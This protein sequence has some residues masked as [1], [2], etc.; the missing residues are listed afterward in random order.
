MSPPHHASLPGAPSPW[1]PVGLRGRIAISFG[2][3]SVVIVGVLAAAT[4]SLTSQYLYARRE[5]GAADQARS[6][7]TLVRDRLQRSSPDLPALLQGLTGRP[8][9]G[10]AVRRGATWTTLGDVPATDALPAEIVRPTRVTVV[11]VDVAGPSTDSALATAVPLGDGDVLVEIDPLHELP[12]TVRFLGA[13]LAGATAAAGLLGLGLGWWAGGRALRPVRELSGA[14]ARIATGDLAH[15]LPEHRDPDLDPLAATVNR[16]VADLEERVRR[17]ARFAG[18]VSHELRSP[19]TTMTAAIGILRHRRT[20]MPPAAAEAVEMLD[21]DLRRFSGLVTDLLEISR[22]YEEPD[23]RD[24]E[25]V[26]LAEL[27]RAVVQEHWSDVPVEVADPPAVLGDRRRLRQVLLNLGHNADRHGEGLVR[28]GVVADRAG[29]RWEVDDDGPGIPEERRATVFERF[30][31]GEGVRD[32]ER[33]EGSGL[34]LAVVAGH[35]RRHG[36]TVTIDDR[37]TGGTRVTVWLPA[38]PDRGE[39]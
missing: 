13:L 25:I 17:D 9:T 19:L 6:D 16:T 35:V 15:R 11:T 20:E 29:A 4:W 18:D 1:L 38:A 7:A 28:I 32:G 37:A 5:A 24:L 34:G 39:G 21:V 33:T 22:Q 36:G 14:A 31:R 23:A 26:D 10:V 27:T 12:D 30:A 3:L 8:G 2:L